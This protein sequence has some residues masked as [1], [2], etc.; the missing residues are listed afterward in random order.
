MKRSISLIISII[1]FSVLQS[2]N[3]SNKSSEIE[4]YKY[5]ETTVQLNDTLKKK[6]GNWVR[7]GVECYGLVMLTDN[8][9]SVKAIKEIKAIVLTIQSDKIKMKA[10]ENISLAPKE[11]CT[12]MGISKGETWWEEEGDLFLTR[13]EAIAF[14]NELKKEQKSAA[15]TKFTID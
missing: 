6:V 4:K 7:E 9:G 1:L 5:T 8:D 11:G 3:S 15:G 13:D 12:K 14:A 2:C 10:L